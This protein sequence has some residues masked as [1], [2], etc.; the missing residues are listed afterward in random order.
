VA[1]IQAFEQGQTRANQDALTSTAV[2][3]ASDIQAKVKEPSQFGGY[4]G[5][6]AEADDNISLE[7]LGYSTNSD[8]E[9]VAADGTCDVGS[10]LNGDFSGSTPSSDTGGSNSVEVLCTSNENEVLAVVDGLKPGNIVS[11]AVTTGS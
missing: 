1:G 9:Y 8:G 5:D 3:I 11:A 6:L 4:D 2:K 7:E 10:S